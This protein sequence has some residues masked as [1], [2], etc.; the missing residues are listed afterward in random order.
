[1]P[2][3]DKKE[4]GR[5]DVQ[6]RERGDLRQQHQ[7]IDKVRDDSRSKSAQD[8]PPAP[9]GDDNPWMGGG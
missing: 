1:M 5:T 6:Q 9:R 3:I 4:P 2:E 8:T 7:P